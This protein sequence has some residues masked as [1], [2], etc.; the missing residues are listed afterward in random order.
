QGAR[1]SRRWR[2]TDW[3]A[4]STRPIRQPTATLS[5]QWRQEDGGRSREVRTSGSSER[6]PPTR[7]L[8]RSS[9]PC[10]RRRGGGPIPRRGTFRRSADLFPNP[11]RDPVNRHVAPA[12][13][14]RPLVSLS[15]TLGHSNR[16]P[17]L[18]LDQADHMLHPEGLERVIERDGGTLG[19]ET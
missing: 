10:R 18:R 1:K 12:Q 5:S 19:S 17:V 11:A 15:Q 7:W 6:W 13:L 16:T 4:Q 3:R 8:P 14:D 9:A 2:T